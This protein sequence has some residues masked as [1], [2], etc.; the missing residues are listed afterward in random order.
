MVT[1]A[2][3]VHAIL[4]IVLAGVVLAGC[5]TGSSDPETEPGLK[6]SS[7]AS[8][9][10][11][12]PP[13]SLGV[14]WACPDADPLTLV[15]AAI[16]DELPRVKELVDTCIADAE[17]TDHDD[18]ALARAAHLGNIDVVRFL[19]DAGADP[20]FVDRDGN[21]VLIWAA[22]WL[23]AEADTDPRTASNKASVVQILLDRGVDVD[24]SGE[25]GHT[26]L[27]VAAFAGHKEVV[28]D[29]L[30][31]GASVDARTSHGTTPLMEAAAT[32][33]SEIVPL[34]VE[35]G[36]DVQARDSRGLTARE[37]AEQQG[38]SEIAETLAAFEED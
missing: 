28:R 27:T 4:G 18:F 16:D 11:L 26:A 37:I 17:A 34:L 7:E 32:G 20:R 6:E 36:A 10:Q 23:R 13:S 19:L 12:S 31:A 22:R 8:S 2:G 9:A 29:L 35:A 1:E 15:D 5:S 3:R 24:E 25:G 30:D 33:R 21:T 38:H 14:E